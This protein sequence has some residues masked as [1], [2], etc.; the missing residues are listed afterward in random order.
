MQITTKFSIGDTVYPITEKKTPVLVS[1]PRCN[2]IGTMQLMSGDEIPCNYLGCER[3]K[4]CTGSKHKWQRAHVHGVVG[5]IRVEVTAGEFCY[6]YKSENGG[7]GTA[8]LYMLDSTGV[9]T[10]TLWDEADLSTSLKDARAECDRRNATE[11][12]AN[13]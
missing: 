12:A 11:A 7:D 1:C 8:I 3:G 6:N 10:G 9:R 13:G 5:Q 2:G 4:I